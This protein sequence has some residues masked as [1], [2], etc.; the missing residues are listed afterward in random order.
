MIVKAGF[1]VK[2]MGEAGGKI[3]G[4]HERWGRGRHGRLDAPHTMTIISL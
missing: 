2:F 3:K 4:E 1:I